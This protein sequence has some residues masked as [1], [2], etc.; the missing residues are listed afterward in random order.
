M[1][2]CWKDLEKSFVILIIINEFG[3][4]SQMQYLC[5]QFGVESSPPKKQPNDLF[6]FILEVYHFTAFQ[7]DVHFHLFHRPRNRSINTFV[8][9]NRRPS[10]F[11]K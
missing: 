10:L 4:L 9:Q 3:K 2:E 5:L 6:I 8:L 11:L 1:E 7:A